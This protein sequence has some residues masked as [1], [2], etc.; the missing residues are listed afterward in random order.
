MNEGVARKIALAFADV[1]PPHRDVIHASYGEEPAE[2]TEPFK[3]KNWRE[4][5]SN[6]VAAH[7]DALLYWFTPVAF[8][9]YLPAFLLAGLER[10]DADFVLD[11]LLALKPEEDPTLAHFTRERWGRLDDRQI[12]ALEAWLRAVFSAEN[13]ELQDAL[14]VLNKR[15]WW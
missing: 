13:T 9:Y 5:D 8:H 15:Y 11:I 2:E 3:G 4:L 7:P 12:E 14:T 10:P 6:V 1:R